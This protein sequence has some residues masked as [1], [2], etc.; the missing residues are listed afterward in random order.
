MVGTTTCSRKGYG[1]DESQFQHGAW[2][3][4]FLVEPCG[5]LSRP[6]KMKAQKKEACHRVSWRRGDKALHSFWI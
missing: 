1:Y 6:F 4:A 2:T 3:E 5:L